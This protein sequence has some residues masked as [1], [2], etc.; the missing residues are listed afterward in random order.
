MNRK[1]FLSRF[2][3]PGYI[4]SKFDPIMETSTEDRVRTLCPMC[5]EV[6]G[7]LY[8]LL[9]E[10][11]VYCQR[12]KYDPKS[13]MKFIADIENITFS[14]VFRMA[15][16]G[17]TY[18]ETSV[19][20]IVNSLF[21]E[22][23]DDFEYEVMELDDTFLPVH[24]TTGVDAL[25]RVLAKAGRYLNNRGLDDAAIA[26][27]DIRYC[28]SGEYAGRVVVPCYY[29]GEVVTFV[30]RDIFDRSDRKYLNPLG[31][32]QSDFLFN[33]DKISLDMVILTEGVFDAMSASQVFPSVASFGKSLSKRQLHLLNRFKRII[34]YWDKDAYLQVDKYADLLQG[35][36][37]VILHAD[38]KDAGSRSKEENA[39]L[40]D[41]A[42]PFK[43]V[44]YEL[45]KL[46]EL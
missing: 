24:S 21:D 34:F 18:L 11:L 22:E 44:E 31:N 37:W 3:F 4:Y 1:D 23:E 13:P 40:V 9:T 2:D 15:D 25:D 7:H 19:E 10:G 39:T 30:A 26:R 12:C 45:F 8:I 5:G 41:N 38:G 43:S 16:S 20:E 36:C 46:M 27:Y 6:S 35:E 33:W 14:D 32:K 28:Y 29:K 17:V 42:V